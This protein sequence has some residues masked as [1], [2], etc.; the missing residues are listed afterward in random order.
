ME[1][2][3][4]LTPLYCHKARLITLGGLSRF[5][6]TNREGLEH[7]AAQSLSTTGFHRQGFYLL[8]CA[9]IG[10]LLKVFFMPLGG[11]E[12]NRVNSFLRYYLG[13]CVYIGK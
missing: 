9:G 1:R 3:K 13:L 8:K 10:T 4:W 12:S 5:G 6:M 11:M 7:F 2:R